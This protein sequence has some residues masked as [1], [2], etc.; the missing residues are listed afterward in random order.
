MCPARRLLVLDRAMRAIA[1]QIAPSHETRVLH[2][3]CG[4]T[5]TAPVSLAVVSCVRCGAAMG[6]ASMTRVALPP[7]R[8]LLALGTFATQ[9]FGAL[10]FVLA[11][12]WIIKLRSTD[13]A[14][15]AGLG[16]GAVCVFAG[17][18]A[19]RG[20]VIALGL[21]AALGIAIAIALLAQQAHVIAFITAPL[22]NV[23]A[24]QLDAARIIAGC[25]AA[26][27]AAECFVA[28]PQAR[29]FAQW[30]DEQIRRAVFVRG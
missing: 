11:L 7:S 3:A 1:L 29:E 21:C 4:A 23:S 10:A 24:Y 14:V 13:G 27:A 22:A 19:Y 30:R 8:A 16:I 25:V 20:S 15:L 9:M 26:M 2:C 18:A 12:M 6:R 5:R 17:G 28:M